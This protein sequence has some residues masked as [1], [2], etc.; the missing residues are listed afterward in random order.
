MAEK[1]TSLVLSGLLIW[2]NVF[3]ALADQPAPHLEGLVSQPYLDLLELAPT[4]KISEADLDSFRKQLKQQE[5]AEKDRLKQEIKEL[6]AQV[7]EAQKQ[8]SELNKRASRDDDE[9]SR[10]RYELQCR[11]LE[12][13]KQIAQKNTEREQGLPL[14]YANKQAKV[15]LI[16]EWPEKKREIAETIH[17][18]RARERR[19]G[20][21]EDIG[22]RPVGEGQEEDIEV[23]ERSIREMRAYGLMPP[24]LEDEEVTAYV[25]ELAQQIAASSDLDVPLKVTVLDSEE[26]NAFALPGGFLFVDSGL[27]EKAETE[28]QLAGVIAHEIAHS[29]ARHGARLMKRATITNL[30]YQAAQIA[31]L[32]FTGGAVGIGT[33]YALQYGF[34]GLGMALD[35]TLLGVSRHYELEADQLGAQYLWNAGYDPKGF[36]AFFDKMASE[37]G[38]VQSASFFRTHPPFF[39]RIVST[40]AEI[41]YL[42]PKEELRTDSS[43]FRQAKEHLQELAEERKVRQKDTKRPRLRRANSPQCEEE[44]EPVSEM[45]AKPGLNRAKPQTYSRDH[46]R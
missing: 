6:K 2:M 20:D 26:I 41:E 33:Y 15:D 10:Q 42:P 34:Y 11:M 38:Y 37:K 29:A 22:V 3:V 8:L 18:G 36:V 45:R 35:L 31:A 24:E 40:F 23:G 7:K 19:Y 14:A 13:E 25:R 1:I 21:V 12:L 5:K 39:E 43:E 46:A 28:S 30:L 4:L 44:R 32:I 16:E 17:A 9:A 27:V